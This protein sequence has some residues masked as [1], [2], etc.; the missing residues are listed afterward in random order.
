M[1]NSVRRIICLMLFFLAL[2]YQMV[3]YGW[4]GETHG[5]MSEN[6]IKEAGNVNNALK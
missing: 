5:N 4:Q 3:A 6:A 2:T 1:N